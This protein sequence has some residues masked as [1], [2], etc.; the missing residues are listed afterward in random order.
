MQ[1]DC[2]SGSLKLRVPR[3]LMADASS[4]PPRRLTSAL[5]MTVLATAGVS[6]TFTAAV[7][8]IPHSLVGTGLVQ[9]TPPDTQSSAQATSAGSSEQNAALVDQVLTKLG[10]HIELSQDVQPTVATIVDAEKLKNQNEFYAHAENGDYLI[11]TPTR[12][13][14]YSVARDIIL[15]VMPV[16]VEPKAPSSATASAGQK[17]S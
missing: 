8:A 7:L 15:N 17:S 16:Q 5:L 2:S 1:P 10:K 6:S 4:R 11:V 3:L 14:L 12:A 9:Q 13:I